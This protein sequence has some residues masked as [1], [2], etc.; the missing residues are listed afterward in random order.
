MYGR[1]KPHNGNFRKS[2]RLYSTED[3]MM[4]Y[5]DLRFLLWTEDF[6]PFDTGDKGWLEI[7]G[8]H[9]SPPL[10]HRI[11]IHVRKYHIYTSMADIG[12]NSMGRYLLS[13]TICRIDC[14]G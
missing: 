12:S 6:Y 14:S 2:I 7:F 9:L 10:P 8:S 1:E 5:K 3:D 13:V 4:L 11:N